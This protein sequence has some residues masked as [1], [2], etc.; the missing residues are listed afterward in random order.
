MTEDPLFLLRVSLTRP[1]RYLSMGRNHRDTEDL[2]GTFVAT[3][4]TE[5]GTPP[6][7]GTPVSSTCYLSI[8]RTHRDTENPLGTTVATRDTEVGTSPSTSVPVSSESEE[9]L[10]S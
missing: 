4:D 9:S 10:V 8:R 2:L 3:R 6:P 5:L 7:N 1:T